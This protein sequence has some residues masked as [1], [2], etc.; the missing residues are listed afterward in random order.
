MK[1]EE[2]IYTLPLDVVEYEKEKE[3]ECSAEEVYEEKGKYISIIEKKYK[4]Y[5]GIAFLTFAVRLGL[6]LYILYLEG[7]TNMYNGY[8]DYITCLTPD[9]IVLIISVVSGWIS[10]IFSVLS[11]RKK[12]TNLSSGMVIANVLMLY[13]TRVYNLR[14]V[15]LLLFK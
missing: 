5:V 3:L 13:A 1:K 4:I 11:C 8:F 10:T 2:E 7:T 9:V 12:E 14:V 15:E 6:Q